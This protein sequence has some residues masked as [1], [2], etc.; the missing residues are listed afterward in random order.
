MFGPGFILERLDLRPGGRGRRLIQHP[1]LIFTY[2]ALWEKE[3]EKNY[4]LSVGHL[5]RAARSGSLVWGRRR[6]MVQKEGQ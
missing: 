5:W 4:D 1:L 3:L 6:R 2:I